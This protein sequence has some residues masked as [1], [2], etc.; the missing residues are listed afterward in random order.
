MSA[1]RLD[2]GHLSPATLRSLTGYSQKVKQI[3]WLCEHHWPHEV[4]RFGRPR[5]AQA[6]YDRRLVNLETGKR[7]TSDA[8]PNWAALGM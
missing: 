1:D 3:E 5:V 6:Y 4:D 2:D 7:V 8:A